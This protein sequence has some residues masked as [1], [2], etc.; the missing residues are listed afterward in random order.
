[1]AIHDS[2]PI[3]CLSPFATDLRISPPVAGLTA[4][5]SSFH[6]RTSLQEPRSTAGVAD[7]AQPCHPVLGSLSRLPPLLLRS[8][9]QLVRLNF[10]SQ[11]WGWEID[12][13]PQLLCF[14]NPATCHPRS[15]IELQS[16]PQRRSNFAARSRSSTESKANINTQRLPADAAKTPRK[17]MP[18]EANLALTPWAN[19][20]LSRAS[21]RRPATSVALEIPTD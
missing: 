6:C 7:P 8:N 14:A 10:S 16:R 9:A 4:R 2:R 12:Q 19:P 15:L 3:S 5:P 13:Q 17:L 1:M 20:G 11:L 21:T 18:D